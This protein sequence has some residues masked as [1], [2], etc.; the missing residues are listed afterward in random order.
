MRWPSAIFGYPLKP[1]SAVAVAATRTQPTARP[2]VIRQSGNKAAEA[3]KE[4]RALGA[5]IGNA[6]LSLSV[7]FIPPIA[8]VAET[9]TTQVRNLDYVEAVGL[10]WQVH[11]NPSVEFPAYSGSVDLAHATPIR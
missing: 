8:R 6:I 1:T 5:G 4:W 9:I 11:T 10:G 3:A 7:V 2:W